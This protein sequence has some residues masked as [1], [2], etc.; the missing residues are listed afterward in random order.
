MNTFQMA[1]SRSYTKCLKVL[2]IYAGWNPATCIWNKQSP[3]GVLE[4]RSSEK[5]I[6]T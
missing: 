3:R 1:T 5:L 2:N 4:E 6:K